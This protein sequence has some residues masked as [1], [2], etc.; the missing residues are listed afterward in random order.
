MIF[1]HKELHERS[2]QYFCKNGHLKR[3][4][5]SRLK[6]TANCRKCMSK[7]HD[8]KSLKKYCK[9][10][11]IEVLDKQYM[12][13]RGKQLLRCEN[14]HIFFKTGNS[15]IRNTNICFICNKRS[16]RYYNEPQIEQ[17]LKDLGLF[18]KIEWLRIEGV[19]D[20]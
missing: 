18:G 2:V 5:I 4:P 8:L 11:R 20:A 13:A 3:T 16:S 15:I 9:K 10:Q 1:P 17:K 14:K 19:Q 6:T 12:Q 7:I